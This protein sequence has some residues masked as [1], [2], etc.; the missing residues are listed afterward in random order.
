MKFISKVTV[1]PKLPNEIS[2][3]KEL[4]ENMWWTWNYKA[5]Q[6]FKKIDETLWHS[7]QRNPVV[8]LK[9]VEQKKLNAAAADEGFLALY[10]E[11]M[12]NFHHYLE[13]DQNTWFKKTHSQTTAG[14][15]AYFCMEYGIHESF[16]M[17]SGG[18]GVLAGDHIKSASDLGIPLVAVGLLYRRGYFIQRIN[19][20]GW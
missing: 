10:N 16:P 7:V 11:V 8:F 12:D 5:Q 3:L 17:Y 13:N 6:L 9:R 18:L 20:Q 1:V 15:I 4:S 14:G 19:A 2:G